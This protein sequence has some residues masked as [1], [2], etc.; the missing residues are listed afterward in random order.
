MP[1]PNHCPL[2]YYPLETRVVTP[3]M[4]CG[5]S[6]KELEHFE[7]GRHTFHELEV[8]P[9]LNLVLCNFCMVDFG[10]FDPTFF[11]LE[12]DARVGYERMKFVRDINES[13][14]GRDKFCT[15]C[16]YRLKFLSFVA[17]AREQHT[18]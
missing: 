6:P 10:S 15:N 14:L 17:A 7:K 9:E 18:T 13:S 8:F 11:G 12:E 5:G 1:N 3:C 16:G 2:C 4:E